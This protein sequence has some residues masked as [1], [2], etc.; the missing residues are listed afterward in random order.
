[1]AGCIEVEGILRSVSTTNVDTFEIR[2][3][4]ES[5]VKYDRIRTMWSWYQVAVSWDLL[6]R[7]RGCPLYF[8]RWKVSL[9][10]PRSQSRKDHV[11]GIYIGNVNIACGYLQPVAGWLP[12]LWHKLPASYMFSYPQATHPFINV[13]DVIGSRSSNKARPTQQLN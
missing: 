11:E 3:M 5:F 13:H 4:I 6:R 2:C 9:E 7:K 1:M 12:S 8:C 10:L